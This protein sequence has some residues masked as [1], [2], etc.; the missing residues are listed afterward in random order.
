MCGCY[1]NLVTF[2]KK[3]FFKIKMVIPASSGTVELFC[4]VIVFFLC[5]GSGSFT[6]LKTTNIIHGQ[7]V[8]QLV[9]LRHNLYTNIKNTQCHFFKDVFRSLV[10]PEQQ[11]FCL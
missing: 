11:I 5:V 10:F 2:E 3:S 9:L 6:T 8:L 7:A 4:C 1:A